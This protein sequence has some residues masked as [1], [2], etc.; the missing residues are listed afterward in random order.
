MVYTRSAPVSSARA[1]AAKARS[2]IDVNTS[3][4]RGMSTNFWTSLALGF[5]NLAVAVT[6]LPIR[7]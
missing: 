2:I 1:A 4:V 5:S 7:C 6:E 3:Q